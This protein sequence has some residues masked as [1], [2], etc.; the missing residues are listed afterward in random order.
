MKKLL[1]LF[2]LSVFLLANAIGYLIVKV[3]IADYKNSRLSDN[4]PSVR[5]EKIVIKSMNDLRWQ[6]YLKEFSINDRIYDVVRIDYDDSITITCSEDNDEEKLVAALNHFT[7]NLFGKPTVEKQKHIFKFVFIDC[8][9]SVKLYS[10]NYSV[11]K[12]NTVL[13]SYRGTFQTVL[14]P[15]PEC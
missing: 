15:P 8:D 12:V 4:I 10:D 2:L 11:L 14:S 7:D 5:T 9:E 6:T 1:H 13:K 3:E